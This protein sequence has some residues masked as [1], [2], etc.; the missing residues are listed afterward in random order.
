[1]YPSIFY[2]LYDNI[3]DEEK[4]GNYFTCFPCARTSKERFFFFVSFFV[5]MFKVIIITKENGKMSSPYGTD[6]EH[7]I[8][9]I[10]TKK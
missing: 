10:F 4:K 5:C 8:D 3:V 7:D 1:M 9:T 2:V 6:K